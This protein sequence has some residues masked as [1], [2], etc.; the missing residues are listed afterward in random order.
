MK[1]LNFAEAKGEQALL[2]YFF[3]RIAYIRS[4]WC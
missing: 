4:P 1:R 2:L 3:S